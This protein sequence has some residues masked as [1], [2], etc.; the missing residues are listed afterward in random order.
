MRAVA[1][2]ERRLPQYE[3]T[4]GAR[5]GVVRDRVSGR[6]DEAGEH[7]GRITGRRRRA[8]DGGRGAVVPGQPQEAAEDERDVGAEDAAVPMRLV[9]DHEVQPLEDGG[10]PLV[11]RQQ[12]P[13]QHVRVREQ[14]VRVAAGPV[15]VLAR[16]V[17]VVRG[18]P[19]PLEDQAAQGQQ[20]VRR[21]RLRGGEVEG[22]RPAAGRGRRAA[23]RRVQHRLQVPQRLSRGRPRRDDDVRP[24]V[25]Q[26]RGLDLVGV[27]ALD[28]GAHEGIADAGVQPVGPRDRASGPGRQILDVRHPVGTGA[29]PGDDVEE[30]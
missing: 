2:Q 6:A 23:D 28:A 14:D 7:L 8:D 22:R 27:G 16:S 19:Q 21:Q 26:V 30:L 9:H 24:V 11:A 29:E 1:G 17:A 3:P 4:G 12:G 5:G 13:V 15:A 25:G 10:E 20:L 18:G